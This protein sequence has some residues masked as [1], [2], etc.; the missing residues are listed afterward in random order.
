MRI[1]SLHKTLLRIQIAFLVV[2]SGIASGQHNEL[3]HYPIYNF[4]PKQYSALNQNWC[5]VQDSRGIMYFVYSC[6]KCGNASIYLTQKNYLTQA[7]CRVCGKSKSL[8]VKRE[9][10]RSF[11]LYKGE[12]WLDAVYARRVWQEKSR[13]RRSYCAK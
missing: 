10:S 1:R 13:K 5:A 2:I 11:A 12:V 6:A 9:G 3:G 7:K 4:S 8:K